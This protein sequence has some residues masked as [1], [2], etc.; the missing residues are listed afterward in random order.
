[1]ETSGKILVIDD[2]LGIREGCRRALEPQGYVVESAS[3]IKDGLRKI[4]EDD[5]DLVLLDIMMPD[6]MG[7]DLLDPIA[8][9]DPDIVSVIITGYA[10]VELAVE[11]IKQGAYDFISKPFDADFLLMTVNQG[12]EKRRLSLE[13][14]RLQTIEEQ[15]AE[16]TRAKEEMERL[17]QFKTSFTLMVAHELRAPISALLS[18]LRT[19]QKGYVPA[20]QQQEILQRAIERAEELL[21]LVN[22]LLSLVAAR[23]ELVSPKRTMYSLEDSLEKI[24]PLFK[25]QAEEKD[26]SFNVEVQQRPLVEANPDQIDQVWSNLISNAVKYTPGGGS[27]KV[28]L[29][30][31]HGWAI[32]TVED[33]GIGIAPE[34]QA[35]IFDDFYRTPEAK[36]FERLGT[37]LGLTLVKKIVEGYGGSIEFESTLGK[38][39]RFSFRL[40]I[41]DKAKGEN[42]QNETNEA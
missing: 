29:E 5:F 33:T 26:L 23:E 3:T 9:K 35:K 8:E 16:L 18:F 4:Q 24:V 38:G 25:A 30:E 12:L 22:D 27:I 32:G 37:G 13:A 14:K 1:M 6:G 31:D 40:P 15:A 36:A 34:H 7:I 28:K 17:D 19:M 21:D 2:E 20:D 42:I 10:T 41:A 11:A 39:S